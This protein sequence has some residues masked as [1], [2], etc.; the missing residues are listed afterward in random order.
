MLPAAFFA[1]VDFF[2]VVGLVSS[3]FFDLAGLVVS[4]FTLLVGF[5]AFGASAASVGAVFLRGAAREILS[6]MTLV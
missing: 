2:G 5:F 6:I 1:V 4:A 3:V